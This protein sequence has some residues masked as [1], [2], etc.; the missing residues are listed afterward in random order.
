MSRFRIMHNANESVLDNIEASGVK[1]SDELSRSSDIMNRTWN[2]QPEHYQFMFVVSVAPNDDFNHLDRMSE[3][4]L[5]VCRDVCHS[6]LTDY[7]ISPVA[8]SSN[9]KFENGDYEHIGYLDDDITRGIAFM[10]DLP[11]TANVR[12]QFN[13]PRRF[14]NF[15]RLIFMLWNTTYKAPLMLVDT[16]QAYQS[17]KENGQRQWKFNGAHLGYISDIFFG[18]NIDLNNYNTVFQVIQKFYYEPQT[19][20]T[21]QAVKAYIDKMRANM[22]S[23]NESVMDALD[24]YNKKVS[25]ILSSQADG[26]YWDER[27]DTHSNMITISVICGTEEML[28]A[29]A[30]AIKDKIEILSD[31]YLNNADISVCATSDTQRNYYVEEIP[32]FVVRTRED[33]PFYSLV[34]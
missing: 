26:G 25:D 13:L 33:D 23:M 3:A 28:W 24:A 31:A 16:I 4:L 27:P 18:D 29:T 11:K 5:T 2:P 7:D 32:D 22:K 19:K 15:I 6:C 17:V 10:E 30:Y 21:F 1:A 9:V 34:K 14:Q 8:Y 20:V 12:I